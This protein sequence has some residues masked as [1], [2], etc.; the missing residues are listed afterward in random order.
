M[1]EA[2]DN[3]KQKIQPIKENRKLCIKATEKPN[4][5]LVHFK[6]DLN[7]IQYLPQ[8]VITKSFQGSRL[9]EQSVIPKGF[10]GY[11]NLDQF[12]KVLKKQ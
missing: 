10:D 2:G 8:P 4:I 7:S 6:Y 3:L 12:I 1:G 11:L 9:P 5:N